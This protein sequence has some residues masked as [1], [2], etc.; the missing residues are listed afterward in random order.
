MTEQ[1]IQKQILDYLRMIGCIA[2]K[3]N[4]SNF[5][6]KTHQ[7]GVSDI[8]GCTKEGRFIAI[9]VKKQGGKP[10]VEQIEFIVDVVKHGGIGMIAYSLDEVI[11]VITSR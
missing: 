7:I 2:V 10:T 9:E 11:K 1:Q 3:F 6:R 5:G 4:N 8:V